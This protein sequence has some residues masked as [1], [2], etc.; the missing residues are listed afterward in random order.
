MNQFTGVSG[1]VLANLLWGLSPLYYKQL[2]TI[3]PIVLLCAQVVLTFAV[4]IVFNG[5]KFSDTGRDAILKAAP[6]ALLIGLNWAAYVAAVMKGQALQAS[7]AYFMAPILTVLL[8]SLVF[9][10]AMSL[11]QKI[12]VMVTTV[13]VA[14]DVFYSGEVPVLGILIA[15]PF[16]IYVIQHKRIGSSNPIGSLKAETLILAPFA[17]ACLSIL[18]PQIQASEMDSRALQLLALI[19]L[20]NALPLLLFIRSAPALSA[21]QL[22]AT[23]FIAPITS[24]LLSYFAFGVQMTGTKVLVLG[25]LAAGMAGAALPKRAVN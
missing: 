1:A 3:S 24:A 13:A 9:R 6:T 8:G 18:G 20:V 16:A 5:F 23:Q 2:G 14:L 11:R 22:G 25:L 21:S 15:M 7:Y 19:G 12:G 4:L 17:L 10:E